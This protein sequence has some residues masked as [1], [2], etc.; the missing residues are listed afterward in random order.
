MTSAPPEADVRHSLFGPL[1]VEFDDRVLAPRDWTLLQ[2]RWA[3][4]LAR[5]AEP[6]PILEL[7][8]GAGHIGLAA[9][10]LSRRQLVQVELDPVAAHYARRNAASARW[11]AHV[12]V[13]VAP[14]SDALADEERFPIVVADPPYLRSADVGRWADD[15]P[16]AIDGGPDGLHVIRQCLRVAARH[17]TADGRL[18]LQTAGRSQ[19]AEIGD[20]L[21]DNP[22]LGLHAQDVREYDDERSVLLISRSITAQR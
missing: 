7:C 14:L 18:L 3:A 19:A 12:D 22:T 6:G 1:V 9:A 13:R 21:H 15:P 10:L 2:S 4:E 5:D 8:A 17:L 20:L 11:H 16:G